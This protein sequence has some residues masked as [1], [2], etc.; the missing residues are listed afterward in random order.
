[1]LTK[2]P[3]QADWVA[4]SDLGMAAFIFSMLLVFFAIIML[5]GQDIIDEQIKP[6][7]K[8]FKPKK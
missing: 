2:I 5:N 4:L 8:F 3:T 1:M 7:I 6:L